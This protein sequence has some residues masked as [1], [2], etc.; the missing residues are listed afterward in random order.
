MTL[1]ISKNDPVNIR[2]ANFCGINLSLSNVLN[3]DTHD[4]QLTLR[5]IRK[6]ADLPYVYILSKQQ[7]K[8]VADFVVSN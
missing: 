2:I 4:I 3:L 6:Y 1:P 5:E 7:I 8:F